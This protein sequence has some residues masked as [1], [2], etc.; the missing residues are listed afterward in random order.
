MFNKDSVNELYV[1]NQRDYKVAAAT[2]PQFGLKP[3]DL[4]NNIRDA[5]AEGNHS[6]AEDALNVLASAGD[7][8]AYAHGFH[9][10]LTGLSGKSEKKATES[11][12]SM[13]I[14]SASSQ[15]PMCGHT[16]LPLH[17]VYQDKE[18]NC[19]PTYRKGMD[20]SYE[21]AVFNNHKIFG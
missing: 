3:S 8:K 9:A 5:I 6:K 7:E 20:E 12:C 15:H 16:N 11:C 19:R 2:S 21:G 17:K 10:F 18:G 14:K 13:I 4:V 1:N